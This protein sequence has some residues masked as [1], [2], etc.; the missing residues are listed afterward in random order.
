M[1]LPTINDV[2]A[3]EPILTNLL[4]GYQQ[5][6]DRFVADRVFPAV[7][8]QHDSGTF[9]KFTKSY[10]MLDQMK[11][12]A[13]GAP[14]P[15]VEVGVETDTFATLQY[16]LAYRLAD[17]IQANSLVPMALQS[18]A[19]RFLAQQ[20]MIRKERAWATDFMAS[21]VWTDG[22]ITNKWSDYSA[23]DPVADILLA[24]RTINQNTGYSANT[25]VCGGI[26]RDRLV[27]HPDVIDRIK[28]TQAATLANVDS[29][30]SS[31]FGIMNLLVGR[32]AYNSANEAATGVYATII[33]DDAL[34]CHV[35][36]SPGI[37]SASAG[38]TFV[39]Q[40]GGG[41]GSMLPTFRDEMNDADVL[42][43]KSQWDQKAVA[44]DL[45][46]FYSDCVD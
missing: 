42:K 46:Y 29:A 11:P 6:D 24:A 7:P 41:S 26:V 33:D 34:I 9:Y 45:G 4:V 40:P 22:S 1:P 10:W 5:A 21:S 14:Y 16:A 2:Q 28:N 27:N 23:S 20:N 38:Y 19:L 25:M 37:F 36:P 32:A 39:W 12:R 3:V 18:A 31:I 13:P 35:N 15:I 30:I 17:E 44:T 8:V 43:M